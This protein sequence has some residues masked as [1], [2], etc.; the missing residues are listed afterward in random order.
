MAD[1]MTIDQTVA[2]GDRGLVIRTAMRVT[3]LGQEMWQAEQV[4]PYVVLD[5]ANS[6]DLV[7]QARAREALKVF[8]TV[9]EKLYA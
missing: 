3:R 2:P 4:L 6:M 8:S 5:G 9:W 7:K 1:T